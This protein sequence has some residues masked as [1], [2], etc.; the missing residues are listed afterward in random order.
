MKITLFQNDQLI[1]F[2]IIISFM[3][4]IA[5]LILLKLY[6]TDS[7]LPLDSNNNFSHILTQTQMVRA[8]RTN[9]IQYLASNSCC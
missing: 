4:A 3:C 9:R 1:K 7:S 5:T 6:N 8:L 2:L